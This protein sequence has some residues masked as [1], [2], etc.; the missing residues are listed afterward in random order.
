[1]YLAEVAYFSKMYHCTKLYDP[2]LSVKS[3]LH[4]TELHITLVLLMKGGLSGSD[5]Y[6][7]FHENPS[8]YLYV[9]KCERF[10][11]ANV[12]YFL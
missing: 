2:T 3:I 7:N 9:H 5:V 6:S 12:D 10:K 8:I 1:M 4:T 11:V